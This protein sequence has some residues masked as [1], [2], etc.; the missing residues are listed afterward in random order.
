MVGGELKARLEKPDD[1]PADFNICSHISTGRTFRRQKRRAG[2]HLKSL[3][4]NRGHFFARRLVYPP[5]S[6]PK[7][8]P[9]LCLSV[10]LVPSHR[11]IT[12]IPWKLARNPFRPRRLGRR[13]LE[14]PALFL[15]T[16]CFPLHYPDD[17]WRRI[18]FSPPPPPPR[19]T[20][21]LRRPSTVS[22]I[23]GTKPW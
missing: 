21:S 19:G 10:T 16:L 9:P 5:Q 17:V 12:H 6:F 20:V 8:Y 11:P 18:T 23:G 1:R 13:L 2:S 14:T 4:T 22:G 7:P 15:P 3:Y